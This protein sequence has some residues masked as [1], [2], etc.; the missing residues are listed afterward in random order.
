MK[1]LFVIVLLALSLGACAHMGDSGPV[2]APAE[3]VVSDGIE[4]KVNSREYRYTPLTVSGRQVAPAGVFVIID[5]SLKNTYSTPMPSQF[6]PRFTLVD[7]SGREHT[8]SKELS[9]PKAVEGIVHDMPPRTP[10]AKRLVFDVPS[11][12]YRLRVFMPVVVKTGLEGSA[13]Q[14]R[15]FYYDIGPLR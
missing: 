15:T 3:T 11:G 8:A 12:K 9:Q 4:F 7:K 6:Q 10:I 1:K 13:A 2:H 5:L 14:G